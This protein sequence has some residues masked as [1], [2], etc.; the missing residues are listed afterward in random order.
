MKVIS[1]VTVYEEDGADVF[2][3]DK[4]IEVISH[5]INS[6]V[7]LGLGDRRITV[8]ASD[9]IRAINNAQNS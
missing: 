6:R 9:L 1:E 2:Y 4:S 8:I 3:K 7:V 5:P